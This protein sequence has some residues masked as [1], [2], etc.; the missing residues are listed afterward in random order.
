M[1]VQRALTLGAARTPRSRNPHHPP[2][3]VHSHYAS[4]SVRPWVATGVPVTLAIL[5][6]ALCWFPC[7]HRSLRSAQPFALRLSLAD[8]AS[9]LDSECD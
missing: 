1:A 9:P 8:N 2:Q 7:A 6:R 4:T 3:T 5:G